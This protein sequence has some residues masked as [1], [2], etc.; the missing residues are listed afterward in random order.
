MTRLCRSFVLA[1]C[2]VGMLVFAPTALA[3]HTTDPR[4]NLQ[5]LGHIVE[6][7]VLG[8]FGGNPDVNTDIA[9]QGKYAY[10]GN[11]DGFSIRDIS[12]ANNP[13]TVSRTFCDGNQGDV[14]VYGDLLVR[15]WNTGAG[16]QG[17][18]GAGFECDGQTFPA[19]FEG[20]H[21]FD[22]SNK[23]NPALVGSVE[24]SARCDD[25][26]NPCREEID[27]FGCGSHTITLVPDRR[28]DR[29]FIYNQTSGGPCPF[30]G[31]IE[32]P[33]DAPEDAAW[34]RNEPLMEAD[35]AHDSG[36]ILGNVN[37]MAVA[38]HDMANVYDIG[39]ND[40]PGGSVTNPKF[41]YTIMEPGVCNVQPTVN[42]EQ[43]C[44]GNWH[45]ATFT[46]D[47]EMIILGWEPG[48]G[49]QPECEA[50]DPAVKKS[51]FFYDADDGSKLGQW[52]LPRA[53]G[54]QE[55]CTLHNYNIVP[56]RDGR[57]IMV[58]GNYQAGTWVLDITNPAN[59]RVLAW[60]DPPAEPVPPGVPSTVAPFCINNGG[61]PLTGAWSSHWYNDL[62]Y[63]S[64]IGEG[65]NIYR[66]KGNG[67]NN[68]L[69]LNRLNPQT[70]EFSITRGR[71]G[72]DDD[73]DDS[74][75]DSDSDSD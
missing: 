34:I 5:P 54:P 61:C 60:T 38:S 9:F 43:P 67:F 32:I 63:E 12:N 8:G 72:G 66:L 45:S 3:G 62:I 49:L 15:A 39:R 21:V 27:A 20:I 2:V 70:Q 17:P 11:W 6:P 56:R 26:P 33:L 52:T 7:R 18:F 23:R 41:L 50:D 65:L 4:F 59:A 25:D 36:V 58:S 71:V 29:V 74:D 73:D 55:N 28:N 51:F 22:I 46:W 13:R 14:A 30:V 64:H 68:S 44:N 35:A 1:G 10:Q 42:V 69:K 40:L 37:M 24:L 75:S 57:D 53:Q 31:I 48:G 19:G 47:G 16:A